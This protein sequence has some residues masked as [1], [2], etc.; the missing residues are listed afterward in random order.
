MRLKVVR[1]S[2]GERVDDPQNPLVLFYLVQ[3][4]FNTLFAVGIID[5]FNFG[6]YQVNVRWVCPDR[7]SLIWLT[8]LAVVLFTIQSYRLCCI[9]L[10][11]EAVPGFRLRGRHL[12]AYCA[13][14]RPSWLLPG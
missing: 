10:P 7:V 6:T 1:P 8:S 3:Y 9:L 11:V 14:Q 12:P 2:E 4:V 13:V 5:H